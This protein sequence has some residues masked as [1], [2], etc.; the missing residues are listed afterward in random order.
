MEKKRD[1]EELGLFP[2]LWIP[3]EIVNRIAEQ[4]MPLSL[5]AEPDPTRHY[6][7]WTPLGRAPYDIVLSNA[8]GTRVEKARI[9]AYRDPWRVLAIIALC[10]AETPPSILLST[11]YSNWRDWKRE[12]WDA[13]RSRLPPDALISNDPTS[14]QAAPEC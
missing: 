7:P 6:E 12:Y 5:A 14:G 2:D 8:L 3:L 1:K 4:N 13:A 11:K 9:L 10:P